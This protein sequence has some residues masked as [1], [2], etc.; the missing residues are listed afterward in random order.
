MNLTNACIAM[1]L[2]AQALAMVHPIEKYYYEV[3]IFAMDPNKRNII[4]YRTAF[5]DHQ[6]NLISFIYGY[7]RDYE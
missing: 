5:M 7:P 6:S 1:G 2:R 4:S 3:L